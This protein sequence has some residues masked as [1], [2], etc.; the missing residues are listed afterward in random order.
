[1]PRIVSTLLVA[2]LLILSA[3]LTASAWSDAGH[4]IIAAIAWRQ[5]T[6]RQRLEILDLLSHHP[7]YRADFQ[8]KL[9]E[10]LTDAEDQREWLF[11]QAAVWP[12]IARGLPE[13]HKDRFHHSTWHYINQPLFLR[14]EDRHFDIAH[15]ELNLHVHPPRVADESM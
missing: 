13:P 14:A 1:M 5:I 12:D 6:P 3:P 9:P 10:K 15:L 7:R 8:E 11:L 2:V 4:R